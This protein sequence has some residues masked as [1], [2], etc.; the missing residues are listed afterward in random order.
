MESFEHRLAADTTEADLLG[1]VAKL[2]ADPAVNGILVQLPLPRIWIPRLV[3][4]A[5][6]P[7]K[8]V[9]GFHVI[10]VGRLATGQ[11]AMVPCTPLGCLMLLR[12]RSAALSGLERGGGRPLEHRRQADGAAPPARELHRHHRPQPHPRPA[13]VCRRRPTSSSRPSAGPR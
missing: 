10:N 11:K 1:L 13:A 12:G 4:N 7:A 3:I 2:N 5:I 9:D 8:D 6:D